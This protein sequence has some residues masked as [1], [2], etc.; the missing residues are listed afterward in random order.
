MPTQPTRPAGS[1]LS[2]RY[3]GAFASGQALAT[4]PKTQS[5]YSSNTTTIGGIVYNEIRLLMSDN[6]SALTLGESPSTLPNYAFDDEQPSALAP[7]A[8]TNG[9]GLTVDG[10]NVGEKDISLRTWCQNMRVT[11]VPQDPTTTTAVTAFAS[12]L[13][14]VVLDTASSGLGTNTGLPVVVLFFTLTGPG[15]LNLDIRLDIRASGAR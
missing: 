3:S 7:H 1:S 12:A 8:A 13:T 10:L 15:T 14:K 11:V 9:L 5:T 4:F 2:L 6:T